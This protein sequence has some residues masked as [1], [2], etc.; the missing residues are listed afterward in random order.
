MQN[1]SP[2]SSALNL[3]YTNNAGSNTVSSFFVITDDTLTLLQVIAANEKNPIDLG[4]SN[5]CKVLYVLNT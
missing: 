3:L 1:L 2:A 4:M 5:D